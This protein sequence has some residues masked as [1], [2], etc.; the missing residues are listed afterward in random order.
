MTELCYYIS[1]YM[2]CG[3]IRG[4]EGGLTQCIHNIRL[5]HW[6]ILD[7]WVCVCVSQLCRCARTNIADGILCKGWYRARART[8]HITFRIN[9]LV[10]SLCYIRYY[11]YIN[12]I[13]MYM[14]IVSSQH[15]YIQAERAQYISLGPESSPSHRAGRTSCETM[16]LPSGHT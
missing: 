10:V 16:L 4:D 14:E 13:C 11:V 2:W 5:R 9:I 6:F 3:Y 1:Y 12:Y 7:E 8:Q 15:I